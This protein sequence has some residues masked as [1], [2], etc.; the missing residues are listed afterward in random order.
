MKP[1]TIIRPVR[2]LAALALSLA[3]AVPR[4]RADDKPAVE[5]ADPEG[6][7]IQLALLLDTSNSMDG[8]IDQAKTQL[9]KVV[10]TFIAAHKDGKV[11]HVEVALYQYGNNGLSQEQNWI[12]QM[13]PLTRDLDK[14][15]EELFAL[16]TNGGEEYC[17]AVITRA[18]EDLAWDKDPN[19]YKAIF[20]AGNEPFTQGKVDPQKA[21][22]L[23]ASHGVVVNTIHCGSESE[24]ISGG[25]KAGAL[26]ADG[27]FLIIDSNKTVVSIPAPQDAEIVKLN[28]ELNKTYV[29]YGAKAEAGAKNQQAQDANASRFASG[30]AA[31]QRAVTKASANYHNSSWDLVD[32]SK[33]KGFDI[34][35]VPAA[36]LPENLRSM[37][38]AT[39][40]AFLD[41]KDKERSG[42]QKQI[43]ELNKQRDAFVAEKRR[44]SS[45]DKDDTLDAAMTRTVRKQAAKKGYS[46]E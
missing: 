38:N 26:A 36:D 2:A 15:S 31:V 28:E 30:G 35:K 20:I 13:Q 34:E 22:K 43:L 39:R 17:G 14:V 24:G 1:S 9:W 21:C 8:L 16:K 27:S 12:K 11:P 23:A 41:Q 46:F 18:V 5:P 40:K 37:D 4:L 19:T 42:L 45:G 32:A 33:E 10:N 44:A 25:W 6:P 29:A 7:R 3:I